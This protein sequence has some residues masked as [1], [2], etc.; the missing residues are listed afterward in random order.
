MVL[1]PMRVLYK[2]V[3]SLLVVI[4]LCGCSESSPKINTA[5]NTINN[6]ADTKNN[7]AK[8]KQVNIESLTLLS[9]ESLKK[10]QYQAQLI[11]IK[12]L[13]NI[14]TNN[15]YTEHFFTNATP[16]YSGILSYQS[17]GLSLYSRI[18]IPGTPAPEDGFPVVVFI[19][20]W[21]G[22]ANAN[23]YDFGYNN[24][25][26][27]AQVIHQFVQA[28]FVVLTPGLRGHGTVNGI[29]ADGTEFI[30][31]WDNGSYTS[32]LFYSIDILNLL[33]G[34]ESLNEMSWFADTLSSP[35]LFIN[36]NNVNIFG[37]SQ[38]GDMVLTTLAVVG[39]NA[40]L[41]QRIHAGAIWAGCFLPR[42]EQLAL[43]GPMG[44]STQAFLSGDGTWTGSAVGKNKEVN[45]NFVYPYPADWIGSP[46]NSQ[47]NWTWQ[48]DSWPTPTVKLAVENKLN[49]MYETFNKNVDDINNASYRIMVDKNE[50]FTVVHQPNIQRY[51]SAMDAFN[52]PQYIT[53]KLALHHSDRDYYSPSQWNEKLAHNI[54]SLGGTVSDYEY[55]ANTHN[56]KVSTH[57][58][59]S[60][61]G[62]TSGFEKMMERNISLFSN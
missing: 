41:K 12:E 58:W 33:A 59:F 36:A 30:E 23:G 37:H 50:R 9:I 40:T 27:Y 5:N 13:H 34:I 26:D 39:E 62:T 3:I 10:R 57:Q 18:D 11:P 48:K 25:S 43:Y 32:P 20:G 38:G 8:A 51:L 28:G 21:I 29:K 16:Y 31:A 14:T 49:Q 4:I 17:E 22:L 61:L 56:M 45:V 54:N 55:R 46:D 2:A 6:E 15:D 52:Y 53:E 1:N 42:S 7:S 19:H 47:G 44:S 24:K 35:Q 60:P